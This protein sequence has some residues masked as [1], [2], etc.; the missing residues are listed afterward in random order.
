[1]LAYL[2]NVMVPLKILE[3]IDK[4]D[5]YHA[6]YARLLPLNFY[7]NCSLIDIQL[8]HPSKTTTLIFS[9]VF[10]ADRAILLTGNSNIVESLS[11][12]LLTLKNEKNVISYLQFF[13]AYAHIKGKPFQII[14]NFNEISFDQETDKKIQEIKT[15]FFSPRHIEGSFE[16]EGWQ[17]I[18]TC[19]LYGDALHS[20]VFKI[21]LDGRVFVESHS[22][23]FDK[24]LILKRQYDG[25]FRIPRPLL[26]YSYYTWN[27]KSYGY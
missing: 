22:C 3:L 4:L 6:Q 1:M 9:A 24:L 15:S 16:K 10:N 21:F 14:S 5:E 23:I 13:G 8:Y 12:F 19:L 7:K 20:G 27:S 18:E 17:R 11:R 25:V 26:S 2:N